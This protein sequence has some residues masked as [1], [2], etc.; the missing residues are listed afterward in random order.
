MEIKP[1]QAPDFVREQKHIQVERKSFKF[2]PYALTFSVIA[3]L[4]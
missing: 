1:T 3:M 2:F 4:P